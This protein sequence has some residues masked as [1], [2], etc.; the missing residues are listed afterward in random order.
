MLLELVDV[1]GILFD[2]A[3]RS[4]ALIA[5]C[6]NALDALDRCRAVTPRTTLPVLMCHPN[7]GFVDSRTTL[8]GD[9]RSVQTVDTAA[10]GPGTTAITTTLGYD[11][12]GNTLRQV[13]QTQAPTG[14]VQTHT[15]TSAYNA[16]DWETATSDDGLTTSYGYDAAGQQRSHTILNGAVPVT[17][18]LDAEGR[19]TSIAE[20]LGGSGP[21]TTTFGYNSNDLVTSAAMPGGVG[22]QAT[23][24]ANS[25]LTHV[26]LSGPTTGSGAT[27]LSSA[28]DYGY[29]ALSR[30][31]SMTWTVNGAVTSTQIAHDAQGRVT[32]WSGHDQRP[33]G[34]ALRQQRQHRVHYRVHGGDDYQQ[35]RL[36][37][38]GSDTLRQTTSY[39]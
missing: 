39:S 12:D 30:I 11:P 22:E 25:R 14:P 1:A 26:G 5:D 15:I 3:P 38:P 36:V 8:D 28:Y 34:V 33:R 19:T 27:T 20:A 9:N 17:S 18:V 31:T 13:R 29:D 2:A 7:E 10:S 23:Y 6:S 16:A 4:L 35:H 21:Y 32:G 37:R 24:D